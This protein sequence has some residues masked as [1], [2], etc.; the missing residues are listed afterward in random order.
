MKYKVIF[1]EPDEE[2]VIVTEFVADNEQEA[3]VEFQII[4]KKFDKE[5]FDPS[6]ADN[7]ELWRVDVPEQSTKI[8]I[9]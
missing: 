6:D 8:E 5:I 2:D 1:Y 7:L 3:I 4:K 9:P